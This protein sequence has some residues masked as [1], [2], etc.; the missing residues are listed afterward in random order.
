MKLAALWNLPHLPSKKDKT[1][2]TDNRPRSSKTLLKK[3]HNF[4]T[5]NQQNIMKVAFGEN[6]CFLDVGNACFFKVAR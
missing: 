3:K 6:G 1:Y 2:Q 4:V 5:G